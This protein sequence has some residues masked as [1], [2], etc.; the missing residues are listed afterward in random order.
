MADVTVYLG[1]CVGDG[2]QITVPAGDRIVLARGWQAMNRALVQNFLHAQITTFSFNGGPA[3]NV[4]GNWGGITEPE[5]E[6]GYFST[7]L[8]YDTGL[9]LSAGESLELDDV[10]AFSYTIT[11]GLTDASGNLLIYRTE[12]PLAMHCRITAA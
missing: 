4:S 12:E 5:E 2:G 10:L 6:G 8:R 3:V 11:D 1:Q 7:G 9:T